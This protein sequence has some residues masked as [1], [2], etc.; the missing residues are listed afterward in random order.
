VRRILDENG[1][2]VREEP[3][4]MREVEDVS[5]VKAE[6]GLGRLLRRK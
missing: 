5:S 3:A 6:R 4:D 1:N 2:V